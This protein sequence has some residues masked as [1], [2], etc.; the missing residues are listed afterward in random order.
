[1]DFA[2][3]DKVTL[4]YKRRPVLSGVSFSIY[5]GE[6]FGIVGGGRCGKT[7]LLRALLGILKPQSGEIVVHVRPGE[8]GTILTE[9][10]FVNLADT[11]G[12]I[13]FG[14]VPQRDSIDEVFPFTVRDMVRMG[15]LAALGAFHRPTEHDDDVVLE[16]LQM[17]GLSESIDEPY[18][19][20]SNDQKQRVLIARA[21]AV[22]ARVLVLDEPVEGMN[23]ENRRAMVKLFAEL[24]SQNGITIIYATRRAEELS[25]TAPRILL[26]KDG[27]AR[28]GKMEQVLQAAAK[29][30]GGPRENAV[31]ST[32]Q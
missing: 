1:M 30:E 22:D 11:P 16:K 32:Q 10:G 7:T 25:A 28:V 15:R 5:E 6:F 17:V 29:S 12:V 2:R 18:R 27:T 13:R 26:L 24:H 3:F 19:D 20:L 23:Q 21:L 9:G 14:Y 4:N 31:R 8:A